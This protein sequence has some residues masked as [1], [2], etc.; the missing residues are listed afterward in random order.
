MK[1]NAVPDWLVATL[2]NPSEQQLVAALQFAIN[3]LTPQA[4]QQY[5][6]YV[7]HYY[8]AFNRDEQT[9]ADVLAALT[10]YKGRNMHYPVGSVSG[11]TPDAQGIGLISSDL[12]AFDIGSIGK[13]FQG[14]G[15]GIGA[16]A[17]GIGTQINTAEAL[18]QKEEQA[19]REAE[20]KKAQAAALAAAAATAKPGGLA[21]TVPKKTNWGL[22]AGIGLGVVVV[23]AGIYAMTK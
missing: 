6:G 3:K 21:L 15:A 16:A 10:S 1:L 17:T 5:M 9:L 23:G 11:F 14:I 13:M 20:I 4:Q 19:K 8:P 2:S 18:K 22:I 12:G 7:A